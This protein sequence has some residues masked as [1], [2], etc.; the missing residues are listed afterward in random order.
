MVNADGILVV[1]AKELRS[2]I[3]QSIEVKPQYGLT[4][5][6]VEKMLMDSIAHA[7]DDMQTRA[8]VE[9]VTEAQQLLDTTNRFLENNS[10]FLTDEE[11]G[12]TKNAIQ[13]LQNLL[14]KGTKDQ[15]QAAIEK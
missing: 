8:L 6:E 14:K 9:A 7:K 10:S 13:E 11:I 2:G 1:K 3:E 5:E 12:S 15:V 4:D